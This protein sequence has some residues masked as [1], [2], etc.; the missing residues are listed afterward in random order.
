MRLRSRFCR[1]K[2]LLSQSGSAKNLRQ[3][4]KSAGARKY[5]RVWHF[6]GRKIYSN[7]CGLKNPAYLCI[8]E[9]L[10]KDRVDQYAKVAQ[11][12]EHDLAKVGVASSNL[13]FRSTSPCERAFCLDIKN[14]GRQACLPI[15]RSVKMYSVY[16]IYSEG[17]NYLYVGITDNVERRLAEHNGGK[18]KTTKPYR[19]FKLIHTESFISRAEARAREIEPKS[20]YGKEFLKTLIDYIV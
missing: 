18:N 19:P 1:E 15:G 3:S 12:V 7:S 14:A 6:S 20:G 16:A 10:D 2:V 4:V 17:R 13:V 11:L 8:T 5:R 9:D